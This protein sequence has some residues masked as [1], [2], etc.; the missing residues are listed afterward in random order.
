MFVAQRQER[1]V[2]GEI[3]FLQLSTKGENRSCQSTFLSILKTSNY[4]E[5]PQQ[6]N[7]RQTKSYQYSQVHQ[8][9]KT[10]NPTNSL[11]LSSPSTPHSNQHHQAQHALTRS[12]EH[13]SLSEYPLIHHSHL[14][15]KR[16]SLQ[17]PHR[18]LSLARLQPC[19]SQCT[20]NRS[21]WLIDP[22][23]CQ[24]HQPWSRA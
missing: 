16:Q 4:S 1:Q 7:S 8:H 14:S 15:A 19:H 17:R 9:F 11:E 13:H 2:N 20:A 5:K 12:S 3:F 6:G 18:D 23:P 22:F 10:A 24:R 21:D